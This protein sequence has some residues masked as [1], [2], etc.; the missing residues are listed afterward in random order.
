MEEYLAKRGV[1]LIIPHSPDLVLADF[2]LFPKLE[3]KL[4][5]ATM[6]PKEFMKERLQLLR[7]EELPVPS[8]D[9]RS[10]VRS[11]SASAAAMSRSQKKQ[12]PFCPRS[13]G[14]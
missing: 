11:A 9:G 1:Q 7:E 13:F 6:T 2:F 8:Q 5:G 14:F 3:K 12:T 4:A 10:A